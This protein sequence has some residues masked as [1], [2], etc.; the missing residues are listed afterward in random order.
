M[1]SMRRSRFEETMDPSS[2]RELGDGGD[3][4]EFEHGFEN[5][6]LRGGEAPFSTSVSTMRL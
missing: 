1:A 5:H 3:L 2:T 4:P 6:E